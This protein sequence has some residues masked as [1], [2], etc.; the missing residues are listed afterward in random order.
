ML[1]N[2][3]LS[4][5]AEKMIEDYFNLPFPN[6]YG[7]R[8][9]YF[10][11]ARVGQRGQ[12]K[13]LVGKGSPVEI[14]EEANIISVQYKQGIADVK[15]PE[16]IRK[17]LIDHNLGIDCSGFIV[18]VLQQHFASQGT[19]LIKKIFITPKTNIFR[20][21]ISQLRPIEQIS[22]GILANEQ[23]SSLVNDLWEIKAG[24]LVVM[25]K[26]GPKKERNHMLLVIKT[27]ENVIHYV[28]ARAWSSEGQYGHGVSTGTITINSPDKGL[29]EQ[30]WEEKD[31][32]NQNNETYW[33][34]R[35]AT[36]LEIRRLKF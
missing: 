36:I 15:Q 26:T 13:V 2:T 33:E 31:E 29:L 11:N 9:P 34:A 22:V 30:T 4:E 23:N 7:V 32:L 21:V 3:Q 18:H 1:K 27:E 20:W 14:E 24:D 35:D 6:I 12:L 28:H 16:T 10:N 17:F 25:L 8:C 19:D 5:P